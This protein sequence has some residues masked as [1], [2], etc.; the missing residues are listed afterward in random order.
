LDV[1]ATALSA[2]AMAQ[3][4]TANNI[5]N[6]NTAGFNPSRVSF[7]ERPD[8]GGVALQ[9]IR[10]TDVQG[11]FVPANAP[12]QGQ[13]GAEAQSSGYVEGSGTDMVTETVQMIENER[14][15][16]ANAAVVRSVDEMLGQF[17]DEIV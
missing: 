6:V 5:A 11:S 15:F 4:V 1:A 16:E 14:G 10:E 12:I 8:L 13:D 3:A 9:D 17:L 2:N 7:E